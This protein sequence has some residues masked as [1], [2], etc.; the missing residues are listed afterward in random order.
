MSQKP[1]TPQ[2]QFLKFYNLA[3]F[4][5]ILATNLSLYAL[6]VEN[7]WA[8]FLGNILLFTMNGEMKEKLIMVEI[9]GFVGLVLAVGLLYAIIFLEPRCGRV[10]ALA[11]PLVIVLFLLILLKPH[12]PRI[13]NSV[14][15]VYM[16]AAC[17]S[18]AAF[19]ASLKEIFTLYLIGSIL[20]NGI[21]YLLIA[22]CKKIAERSCRH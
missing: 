3:L 2:T 15:F 21:C 11:I 17:I 10:P 22:P 8:L 12:A 18:P 9:G 19:L 20:Y 1:R 4:S 16:S 5:L 13:F 14:G 7:T 6:R